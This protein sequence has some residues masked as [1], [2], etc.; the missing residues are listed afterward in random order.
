MLFASIPAASAQDPASVTGRVTD[1]DGLFLAGAAIIEKGTMNATVTDQNGGYSLVLST[2]NPVLEVSFLGYVTQDV[3]VGNQRV[4]DIILVED[5]SALDEV[6]VVGYGH[7]RKVSVVGAQSTMRIADVKMPTGNLS[8]AL[9]GRIAGIVSVT[10]SGE[11][12]HD[13]SDIWIRG[14]STLSGQSSSPLILVDGVERSLNNLDPDDVESFTVLKDASATA[15]YGVRG[16]NGVII[17]QTKPG[18]VGTPKFTV[19]YYE[20]FTRMTRVPKMADAY[21]YMDV[22]NEAYANAN[23]GT[24]PLYSQE[25]IVATKKANGVLYND[26]PLIYNQYL[27]PAVNWHK[28]MFNDWGHNR[29]ANASVR[30]GVPNA[31]YYV[32]LSYYGEEG[33]TKNFELENYNTKMQ[34]DRFNFTSNVNL[35]PTNKTR[36]DVGISG[37]VSTGHYPQQSAETLFA[38]TMEINPVYLPLT[39]PDGS[40]PGINSNGDLRNPYM[41]LALRGYYQEFNNTINTNLRVT[42]DLDFWNWSQ[43]FTVSAMAAFDSYNSRTLNYN[44]WSDMY[45]F[46]ADTDPETGLWVEDTIFDDEGNYRMNRN[47]EGSDELSFGNSSAATRTSYVEASLNYDRVFGKH[48]VG[49]L[50]LFNQRVYRNLNSDSLIG[51]LAYKSRGYA[52][53]LTYSWDDR[54][55][56][57]ANVGINGSENF[58]PKN[59]YGTFPAFGFGWVVSNEPFWERMSRYVSYFKLRYTIGWV[60]SDSV[61]DRRFMYQGT[62]GSMYGLRLGTDHTL[63]S[64][65]GVSTYGVDVG[66]SRSRKQDVGVDIGLFQDKFSLTVDLFKEYRDKIFLR[67]QSNPWYAG[68]VEAPYANM[69]VV[70]NKGIEFQL[71]FNQKLGNHVF[72]TVRGNATYNKDKIIEDDTPSPIYP[73]LETRGT[74][75]NATWGY[76]ADGLFTSQEEIDNHAT[77][78]GTVQVGDIKYRDLNGDGRI[79]EDDMTVIGRGDVPRIYYGFGFDLQVHSFSIGA[80]FQGTAQADRILS[81]RAIQPFSGQNGLDNLYSNIGDRWSPDDPTN[82]NVFYPRLTYNS[83]SNT[84]NTQTSTWWKKDMSFLRLKQL[85]INYRLPQRWLDKCFMDDASVYLMGTNLFTISKFKLWDPELNTSNGI[86]YPNTQSYSIGVKFSF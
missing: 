52:G 3:R 83:E 48:R 19:D 35:K 21:T 81:G 46:A 6:V 57:E 41:D 7:Q 4:V 27:Y 56:F 66:W 12:G 14:L 72:L 63:Q 55:L 36:I 86:K 18:V 2:A 42:Q 50:M 53:R 49:G 59:R 11:P 62:M 76:I 34:Y 58:S 38:S 17:V 10:R 16:A 33:M 1:E 84:N 60:G 77:Q 28:E 32:S 44:R 30:G 13:D 45:Y 78:F 69:G 54:Y 37:Y 82:T 51:S 9:A 31:N 43:G 25:Y 64:G 75:V 8:N 65:W 15:V 70:E 5:V 29:R 47:R 67:R 39:M 40:L 79:D 74:S 26:N 85:N 23:P 20:S 61:T 24:K 80:I 73:W 22:A 68:Y 71:E